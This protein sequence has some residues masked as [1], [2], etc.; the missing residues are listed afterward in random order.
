MLVEAK[1]TDQNLE[2]AIEIAYQEMD[3]VDPVFV[4]S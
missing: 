3:P 1:P 4:I 2:T